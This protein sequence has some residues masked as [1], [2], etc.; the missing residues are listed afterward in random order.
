M[1]KQIYSKFLTTLEK[2]FYYSSPFLILFILLWI[3]YNAFTYN[4]LYSIDLNASIFNRNSEPFR[5]SRYQDGM[6]DNFETDGDNS[7]ARIAKNPIQLIL[8]PEAFLINKTITLT[9]IG[10]GASN[11]YATVVCPV[12]DAAEDRSNEF[13]LYNAD[14]RDYFMTASYGE[15]N[16][17]S[18]ENQQWMP[19]STLLDGLKKNIEKS[20]S[21]SIVDDVVRKSDFVNKDI[22]FE[23]GL[24][25]YLKTNIN[26]D[27]EFYVYLDKNVQLAVIRDYANENVQVNLKDLDDKVLWQDQILMDANNASKSSY[28]DFDLKRTGL[29]KLSFTSPLGDFFIKNLNIN[30]NK[31]IV[32][33]GASILPDTNL[34]LE[35]TDPKNISF[36]T[37]S[38]DQTI[39]ISNQEGDEVVS[40][41]LNPHY[42]NDILLDNGQYYVSFSKKEF[43]KIKGANIAI[44][45]DNYFDPFVFD[46]T[47]SRDPSFVISKYYANKLDGNWLESKIKVGRSVIKNLSDKKNIEISLTTDF[48]K[49][50]A[51][52]LKLATSYS[53]NK[54]GTYAKDEIWGREALKNDSGDF[55]EYD[56]LS[57]FLRKNTPEG[58]YIFPDK[59]LGVEP[60]YPDGFT[61]Y[62]HIIKPQLRGNHEL[63]LYLGNNLDLKISGYILKLDNVDVKPPTIEISLSLVDHEYPIC[64]SSID[65][66]D[67]DFAKDPAFSVSL[68]CGDI[69]P[70][71]YLLSISDG[72][73]V[74]YYVLSSMKINTNKIL[75]KDH[76]LAL[77]PSDYYFNTD[78]VSTVGLHYWND[79]LNQNVLI[80][81]ANETFPVVLRKED[82]NEIINQ[83]VSP[84]F[85]RLNTEKGILHIYGQ[86]FAISSDSWFP[87]DDFKADYIIIGG[88]PDPSDLNNFS[89][90]IKKFLI[91]ID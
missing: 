65:F 10:R 53:M 14:L 52:K 43:V 60:I 5:L 87:V 79:G 16:V 35:V 57:D 9:S 90:Y 67:F 78:H 6:F 83:D 11:L 2:L 59:Y 12:C 32:I 26:G 72:A 58:S 28:F 49:D 77:I 3:L 64:K 40:L 13:L 1:P 66:S 69:V 45:K 70:G 89:S 62:D 42:W 71:V 88:K 27:H 15:I 36:L 86:N 74:S 20:R 48:L 18:K 29:Y 24:A 75:V 80:E 17:F 84:G 44:E 85:W 50:E 38:T 8:N 91:Y 34:Y 47:N 81:S 46:L 37:P 61:I 22:H 23:S 82:K 73:P 19:S 41:N 68:E 4:A 76:L 31:I 30:T 33:G 21:V 51:F 54:L 25:S 56:A 55:S 63:L 39:T 7:F